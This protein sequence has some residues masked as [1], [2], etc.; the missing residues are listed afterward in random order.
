MRYSLAA[1]SISFS[2]IEAV[3]SVMYMSSRPS[4]VLSVVAFRGER[5]GNDSRNSA[6]VQEGQ[7]EFR[8]YSI[9]IVISSAGVRL[10]LIDRYV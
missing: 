2:S 9:R 7:I 10:G 6:V 4:Q 3:S 1:L 8:E 5:A